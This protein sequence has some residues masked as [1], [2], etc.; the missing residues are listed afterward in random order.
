MFTV[1]LIRHRKKSIIAKMIIALKL[2]GIS[3]FTNNLNILRTT[4]SIHIKRVNLN[5]VF[6]ELVIVFFSLSYVL[7]KTTGALTQIQFN[8]HVVKV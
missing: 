1:I 4:L 8:I 7:I 6:I 3:L 5:P 2:Q